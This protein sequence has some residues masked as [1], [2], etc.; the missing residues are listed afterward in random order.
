MPSIPTK[1]AER[2]AAVLKKFQPI[3]Q[4]ARSRDVNESDTVI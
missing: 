4:S 3:V 2:L 1:A